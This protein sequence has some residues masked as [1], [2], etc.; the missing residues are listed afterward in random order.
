MS[1]T[2][3]EWNQVREEFYQG[4]ADARALQQISP[5]FPSERPNDFQ[6]HIESCRA[7]LDREDPKAYAYNNGWLNAW[8]GHK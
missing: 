2:D 3:S 8:E 5:E 4:V 1:M 6:S 7:A